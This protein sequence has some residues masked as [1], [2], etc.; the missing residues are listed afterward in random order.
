MITIIEFLDKLTE[1][2]PYATQEE[3]QTFSDAFYGAGGVVAI[4]S[5][6]RQLHDTVTKR[7]GGNR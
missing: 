5:A 2:W 7:V 4:Y 3:K 1:I 6:Y